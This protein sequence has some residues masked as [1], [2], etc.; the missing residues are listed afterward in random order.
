MYIKY[1]N[2]FNHHYN[3]ATQIYI[4]INTKIRGIKLNY[5]DGPK[6]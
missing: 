4:N 1:Y 5:T 3:S 2:S 6:C